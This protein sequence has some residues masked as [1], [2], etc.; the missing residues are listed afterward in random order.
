MA[1]IPDAATF[2]SALGGVG[3]N[4]G[5][6]YSDGV[7]VPMTFTSTLR[8]QINNTT[9]TT[10]TTTTPSG[11]QVFTKATETTTPFFYR[12]AEV[13]I[14]PII[15]LMMN[16]KTIDWSQPKRWSKKD[17]RNGSVFF[18][19]TNDMGQNQDVLTLSFAG[20]TGNIDRRGSI[21]VG[22]GG[23]ADN[24]TGAISR[25]LTWHNLYL[26]SREPVV[27]P[28][29][30]QNTITI[31]MISPLFPVAIDFSGFFNE[32]ITFS[33]NAEKPNSRDYT[34]GFTVQRTDPDL[35]LVL[36]YVVQALDG[37][38]TSGSNPNATIG[39]SN[40]TVQSP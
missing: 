16:P 20:N 7:R 12:G 24:D 27:I 21:S 32:V 23:K 38:T 4:A 31:T 2:F 8:Q 33:E 10:Q 9:T 29:G 3:A 26:L 37:A 1:I 14:F 35:D 30:I 5:A 11:R 34:F 28:P 40:V 18:H 19:F 39:G 15:P 17:V 13:G 6:R 36:A 25:I 22:D